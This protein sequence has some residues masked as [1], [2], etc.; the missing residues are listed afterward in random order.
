MCLER[1]KKRLNA[2]LPPGVTEKDVQFF[3]DSQEKA[4]VGDFIFLAPEGC[5]SGP[6]SNIV[7]PPFD[8]RTDRI[9]I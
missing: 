1:E 8:L 9:W 7:D 3:T 2:A 4:R 6:F 5:G